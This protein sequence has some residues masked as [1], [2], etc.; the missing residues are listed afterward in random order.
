M[1]LSMFL[2]GV[3][4][5]IFLIILGLCAIFKTVF[6][7]N[8]PVFR[9]GLALFLIYIGLSMLFKGPPWRGEKNTVLFEERDLVLEE[10]GEYNVIFGRGVIDLTTLPSPPQDRRIEVN[11]VFGEG[12]LRIKRDTPLTIKVNSAFSGVRLPDGNQISM[13]EYTYRS[14]EQTGNGGRVLV[15]A[16]V[17]FGSLVFDE[18]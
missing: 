9:I 7:I 6:H 11:V 16:K 13:G 10:Q 5:G 15:E 3:F 2:S 4:W 14:G 17:V 12:V 8:I 1:R 18:E